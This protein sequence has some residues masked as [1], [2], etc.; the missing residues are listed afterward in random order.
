MDKSGVAMGLV[1]STPDDGTIRLWEY[2][3]NRIVPELRPYHGD[4]GS[5][6][7][8]DKDGMADYLRNRLSIHNHEGIGE[9]H[10][11]SRAMWNEPLMR[12][13]HRHGEK[14]RYPSSHPFRDRAHSLGLRSRR[15]CED[16]LG[17][18]GS[19]RASQ[20]GL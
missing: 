13:S 8:T 2:A 9:F 17:T 3:P 12:E 18:C 19:G 1:S 6:N 16:H 15:R 10:I 7:W 11:R 5:S 20:R 4:A 14:A